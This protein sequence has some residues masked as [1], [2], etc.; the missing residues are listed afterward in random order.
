MDDKQHSLAITLLAGGISAEREVSLLTGEQ[1]AAALR[2]RGHRVFQA[3]VAPTNLV[4]L[5]HQPCDVVFPALHGAF[6]EDGGIQ[7]ILE[8]RRLPFVGSDSACSRLAMDKLATKQMLLEN[9]VPTPDWQVVYVGKFKD[10]WVPASGIGYPCV[11]KPIAE[12]SSVDCAVCRNAHEA[13][14]HLTATLP[15]HGS[16]LV[17]R[18]IAGPELTVG[19]IN[20]TPLPTIEI[21][22]KASFYDYQA[23]YVRPDTQYLFD[24]DLPSAVL[25]MVRSAALETWR[26]VGARHLARVDI[27]VDATI[28]Q[29]VVLEINTMPGFT[30]HSLVPKAAQRAGISFDELCDRLV[31]MAHRDGVVAAVPRGRK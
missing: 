11:I 4:A 31:R 17:E 30:S 20:G 2:R 9:S 28:L 29:P 22:S 10:S 5:D 3:D 27:M 16:M 23:K 15:R 19:I 25:D 8:Q 21:R 26:L 14:V 12:G 24:I 7:E 6:G 18:F 13:R 1:I